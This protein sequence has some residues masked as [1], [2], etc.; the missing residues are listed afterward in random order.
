MGRTVDSLASMAVR[1]P[2][3]D[4]ASTTGRLR[5]DIE[6][7]LA[8]VVE[9][10]RYILGPEV[11]AFEEEIAGFLGVGHAI[12]VNS[13]TDALVI[14]LRACGVGVGNRVATSAFSFFATPEAIAVVGAEAEF[15]DIDAST[16][17]MDPGSV[18]RR[19]ADVTAVV[20]V[21]LYGRAAL[22]A[23][24]VAG[25]RQSGLVVI[26]DCAQSFG[27]RYEEPVGERAGEA[28]PSPRTGSR[29][30]AAAYSFFPTKNL[31]GVGDGGMVTTDDPEVAAH[32]RALRAHG[33]RRK[34][35]HEEFGYNSRLDSIQAAVLRV[36]LPFV[37]EWNAQRREA[38]RRYCELLAGIPGLELPHVTE[39]HVFHQFT[40]RCHGGWR[41]TLQR[42]LADEGIQSVVY[43][44]V[45]LDQQPVYQ[46]AGT[47]LPE[48]DRASREVLS[49]PI[50]PGV[51]AAVQG[52]VAA[53]V[54]HVG[55]G[56]R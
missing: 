1:I 4:P 47:P 23:A 21:H 26:E 3:Y 9:D 28:H 48:A 18:A 50:W 35:H 25:Q 36:K 17:G 34:Y 32:A 41:D 7:A 33:S 19:S 37:D 42:A 51:P 8:G 49:L 55:S 15:H 27:A 44:P 38:A 45:P 10:G 40:V 22:S 53:V 43:Y 14:A 12:G 13:G 29:A 52:E 6:R 20:P 31:G 30:T 16:F 54:A 11:L 2:I 46:G 56:P 24:E 39:E 5:R